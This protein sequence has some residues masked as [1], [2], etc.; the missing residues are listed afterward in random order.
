MKII[1]I[2][3]LSLILLI[4]CGKWPDQERE[5]LINECIESVKEEGS[6]SQKASDLCSCS[7]DRFIS[8]VSWSEY[9]KILKS[10]LTKDEDYNS[11]CM[12]KK[13]LF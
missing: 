2:S 5:K 8:K 11:I 13:I 10:E 6:N 12:K 9:Q 1:V 7:I 3:F 4:S